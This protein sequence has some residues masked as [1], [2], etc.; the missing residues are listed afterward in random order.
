MQVFSRGCVSVLICPPKFERSTFANFMD[1]K[2]LPACNRLQQKRGSVLNQKDLT[3]T[4]RSLYKKHMSDTI[5]NDAAHREW[6][7]LCQAAL[8]ETNTIKLLE[9]IAH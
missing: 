1:T 4:P 3:L 2:V 5:G 7:Q 8:F 6:R 9:R